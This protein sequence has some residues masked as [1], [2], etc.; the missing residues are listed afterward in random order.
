MLN[1]VDASSVVVGLGLFR[2]N[3][4]A[5]GLDEQRLNPI[6]TVV[7]Q[8]RPIWL[9]K[10]TLRFEDPGDKLILQYYNLIYI[11]TNFPFKFISFIKKK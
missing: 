9:P 7:Y 10:I 11:F 1:V 3:D 6:H 4:P 5:S 8:S 2:L